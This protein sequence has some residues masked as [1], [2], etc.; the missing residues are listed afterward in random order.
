MSDGLS[1]AEFLEW[2][3][4]MYASVAS[5]AAGAAFKA[6]WSAIRAEEGRDAYG[7]RLDEDETVTTPEEPWINGGHDYGEEP[8]DRQP[9]LIRQVGSIGNRTAA[10]LHFGPPLPQLADPFLTP[11]GPTVIYGKGGTGKG[12]LACWLAIRLVRDGHSVMVIDYEGHEREWGSRLRGLGANEDELGHVHYRAPF[13]PDWSARTGP[14]STVASLVREDAARLGVTFLI[15]DSY[16]F[17]TAS[18]DTLGGQAAATEYFGA[19]TVIGLPSLTIAHV[20]GGAE[21][22]ADRP[23][24]SV[25]VHNS[26]R[27]T[28][29][30]EPINEE[31]P[32]A[33][34]PDD[35]RFGPTIVALELRNK[36]SNARP[37]QP[38][39]FVTFAFYPD[40]SIEVTTDQPAGRESIDL[41]TDALR[42]GPKPIPK[43]AAVIK[44]DTGET[45]G[46]E[47]IRQ[48]LKRHPDRFTPVG[49]D[50]PQLWGLA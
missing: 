1:K 45:L 19:L 25:F 2:L 7:F 20:T 8:E 27:E 22:F 44:A 49:D 36:K 33:Y 32:P 42:G 5:E 48:I 15:V 31:P 35:I 28:W 50:R 23:F 43:I 38:A 37:K 21:R 18:G 46:Q 34:D 3:P 30:V 16:S 11:E 10:D 14:L 47:T 13:G 12:M 40:H 39:Q 4:E 17:A 24:G 29:A 26:A 9:R 41:V 6:K